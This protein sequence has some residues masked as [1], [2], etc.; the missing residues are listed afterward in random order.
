MNIQI[1]HV[2]KFR[3]WVLSN[4]W[5]VLRGFIRLL[6]RLATKN[7]NKSWKKQ[8][9]IN[10]HDEPNNEY[11]RNS[12]IPT[13]VLVLTSE[14][15]PN[16]DYKGIA[17]FLNHIRVPYRV[18][19]IASINDIQNLSLVV[20]TDEEVFNN[21]RLINK[22]N[23][24]TA[25]IVFSSKITSKNTV[26]NAAFIKESSSKLLP[27]NYGLRSDFSVEIIKIIRKIVKTPLVTGMPTK[28]IGLRIDDVKGDNV[29][30]YL[31]EIL[32]YGWHPNLGIF[33]DDIDSSG[34]NVT[35]Y[36]SELDKENSISI[37]P[38]SYSNEKFIFYNYPKGRAYSIKEFHNIWIDVIDKFD[39]YAF[40]VSPV[41]NAHFHVLS[42]SAA[43]QVVRN[44]ARYF[45]SELEIDSHKA[46]PS[47]K[48]WPAGDPL[49]CTGKLNDCGVFQ[50]SSGDNILDTLSPRSYYDFLMHSDDYNVDTIR[51]R[52][53]HRLQMSLDCGFAAYITT[54]EYLINNMGKVGN[55]TLWSLVESDLEKELEY[56]VHKRSLFSIGEEFETRRKS[57]INSIKLE[58]GL[59][60]VEMV[61]STNTDD[62]LTVFRN[63]KLENV[64]VPTYVD[65][66][67]VTI[68]YEEKK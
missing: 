14:K 49:H 53:M 55:K 68:N 59:L 8:L 13:Q 39:K 67:E 40:K 46:V 1:Q 52:I 15:I 51:K 9:L 27:Y 11:V 23:E 60:K 42:K 34:K 5:F 36:L 38:H 18:N 22:W 44:G 45:F 24:N 58:D 21:N 30:I 54:H 35:R 33:L 26:D 50:L 66:L 56:K 25:F 31:N 65:K 17:L 16:T 32:K 63:N 4:N 37:S 28:S 62:N 61:G 6:G 7:I 3:L 41:I 29:Q 19:N 12:N 10:S 43:L 48:Y 64:K 2:L 20:F 57:I 47:K